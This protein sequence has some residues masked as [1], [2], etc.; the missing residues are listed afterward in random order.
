MLPG[1]VLFRRG[2]DGLRAV[3]AEPSPQG[4]PTVI[5]GPPRMTV[6]DDVVTMP[7]PIVT[8]QATHNALVLLI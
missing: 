1:P 7:G 8:L 3:P 6:G 4:H 5:P 2:A